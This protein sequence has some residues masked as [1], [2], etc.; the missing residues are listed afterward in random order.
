[1]GATSLAA[2]AWLVTE[3][4]G[5]RRIRPPRLQQLQQKNVLTATFFVRNGVYSDGC[6]SGRT[7]ERASDSP[8][9][10]E[11]ITFSVL[12]AQKSRRQV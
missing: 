9:I 11:H 10:E 7:N 2:A 1:M 12:P 5:K 4:R 3:G 8:C 6:Y